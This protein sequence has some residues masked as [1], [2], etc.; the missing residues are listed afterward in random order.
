[1]FK[2]N[3]VV[4]D[5]RSGEQFTLLFLPETYNSGTYGLI[6]TNAG[7]KYQ[8]IQTQAVFEANYV[9][10]VDI[11]IMDTPQENPYNE[12]SITG[13]GG[14]DPDWK[15][16][17]S[18]SGTS[19]GETVETDSVWGNLSGKKL[20]WIWNGKTWDMNTVPINVVNGETIPLTQDSS[21]KSVVEHFNPLNPIRYTMDNS[22]TIPV[23]PVSPVLAVNAVTMPVVTQKS[24]LPWVIG[25]IA[26]VLILSGSK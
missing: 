3:D 20:Q 1:M 21:F 8:T 7:G 26:L 12:I 22:P 19:L 18:Y 13:P 4:V 9:L 14:V 25:G 6:G 10:L 16:M 5:K 2:I 17:P 23:D 15:S 11:P 24:I